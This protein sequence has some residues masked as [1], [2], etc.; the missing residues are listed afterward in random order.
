MINL[1]GENK[2]EGWLSGKYVKLSDTISKRRGVETKAGGLGKV[3]RANYKPAC[4]VYIIII[5]IWFLFLVPFW[6]FRAPAII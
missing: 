1:Q 3:P 4:V 6:F 5:I 2:S